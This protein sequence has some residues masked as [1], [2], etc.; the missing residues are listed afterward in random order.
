MQ[1][2]TVYCVICSI[3]CI[4]HEASMHHNVFSLFSTSISS[5]IRQ[6][7]SLK[8]EYGWRKAKMNYH[9]E[10]FGMKISDCLAFSSSLS[11]STTLTD[12]D[13]SFNLLDDEKVTAYL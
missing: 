12:L 5:Y 10:K 7:T 2:L 4:K 6:L 13:L 9:P 1:C 3:S 11:I 8:L